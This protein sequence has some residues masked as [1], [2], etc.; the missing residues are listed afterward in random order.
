MTEAEQRAAEAWGMMLRDH[1]PMPPEVGLDY[2][3]EA[4]DDRAAAATLLH[5][6]GCAVLTAA[7]SPE[8]GVYHHRAVALI[9]RLGSTEWRSCEHMLLLTYLMP[10]DRGEV[11]EWAKWR[12]SAKRVL[13]VLD[14]VWAKSG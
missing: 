10:D 7:L 3:Q 14:A 1:D 8:P 9:E 5:D 6:R 2:V 12:R 4:T 13:N 11:V